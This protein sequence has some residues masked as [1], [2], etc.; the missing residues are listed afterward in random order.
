MAR[1]KRIETDVRG[2]RDAVMEKALFTDKELQIAAQSVRVAMLKSLPEPSECVP[3]FSDHFLV[4]MQKMID[5]EKRSVKTKAVLRTVAAALILIIL[6]TTILFATN[7]QAYADFKKWV[8]E[9]YEN[10]VVYKFFED[11]GQ[12]DLPEYTFGW[13][14]NGWEIIDVKHLET[15]SYTAAGNG[16]DTVYLVYSFIDSGTE[17]VAVGEGLTPEKVRVGQ[18]DADFYVDQ[19]S[20]SANLL[21]LIDDDIIFCLN[22]NL[23]KQTMIQIAEN[24]KPTK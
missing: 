7:P 13:L 8:R 10:S 23:D 1:K 21:V 17:I 4:K 18:L 20:G 2:R 5:K 3:D 24:I 15:V 12:R 9:I 11:D 16:N 22:A 14:P 6:G 19:A